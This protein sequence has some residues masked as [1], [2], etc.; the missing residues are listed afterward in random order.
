MEY[1]QTMSGMESELASMHR[2]IN[3]L[4]EKQKQLESLLSSLPAGDKFSAV[5]KEGEALLKK[6][7]TWDED[8]VQRKSK[9]YDDVEN[10]P[11][12]FTA[13]YLFLINQTESDI[14]RVNQPSLDRL[15][16]LNMEWSGLKAKANEILDKDIPTLN[17]R[18]WDAGLGAIW[19]D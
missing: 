14:P 12:K 17:K 2:M 19:K 4:Y 7:K 8:M 10:F 11:N 9:A 3:S 16:Q 5:R 15:K 1:H 6:M 13:N 18:L